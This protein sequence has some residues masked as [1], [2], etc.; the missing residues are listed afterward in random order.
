[1]KKIVVNSLFLLSSA[2]NVSP[3]QQNFSIAVDTKKANSNTFVE[4]EKIELSNKI[5]YLE[6][7]SFDL[8]LNE[9]KDKDAITFNF[10]IK[11]PVEMFQSY[12]VYLINGEKELFDTLTIGSMNAPEREK[13]VSVNILKSE[14][15]DIGNDFY[16]RI[17]AALSENTA[18]DSVFYYLDFPL[19]NI[20]NLVFDTNSLEFIVA[21]SYDT[22]YL[23]IIREYMEFLNIERDVYVDTY[24][25]FFLNDIDCTYVSQD[26]LP[27]YNARMSFYLYDPLHLYYS[28]YNKKHPKYEDYAGTSV[29][30][31]ST[32]DD[33]MHTLRLN[34][35]FYIDSTTLISFRLK[36]NLIYYF[37]SSESVYFPVN[38]YEVFK[39]AKCLIRFENYGSTGAC[40]E[41]PFTIHFAPNFRFDDYYVSAVESVKDWDISSEVVEI[42]VAQLSFSH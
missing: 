39:D 11:K 9:F 40:I 31:G 10:E 36:G 30:F 27:G 42:W 24:E 14:I 15:E 8:R 16:I 3:T 22:R 12:F 7:Q 38:Y 23:T 34:T 2:F 4:K 18:F 37:R 19:S 20:R 28:A 1:M 13:E 33:V 35:I 29:F 32:Y 41:Y 21:L 6:I 17:G 5:R 26:I 25:S